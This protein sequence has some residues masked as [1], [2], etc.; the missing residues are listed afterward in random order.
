M[1]H[2]L[3]ALLAAIAA[4]VLAQSP[5]APVAP[6]APPPPSAAASAPETQRIEI[7]GGRGSET[8]QRR[9]ATAAKTIIGRDEIDQYGDSTVG[10]VLRR[11]PGV[12]TGGTPGRGGP[13]R[14]RGL[15]GGYTQLLIDGERI[16][17][18]FSLESITPDQVERIEI[19]RAPTAETGAR[20]IAGTINI[21]LREGF[22]KRLND[23]NL[24]LSQEAGQWARG[25]F[26]THNDSVDKLTYNLTA[27][28][29][30]RHREDDSLVLTDRVGGDAP[31]SAREERFA[32]DRRRGLSLG[33][34]LQWRL[35][36]PGDLLT[37]SPNL[38]AST[39]RGTRDALRVQEG[40]S[41]P[42]DS[43]LTRFD[44]SFSN[45]RLNGQWRQALGPGRLEASTT[46]SAFR[47]ENDSQR[48]EFTA[49]AASRRTDERSDTRQTSLLLSGKYTVLLGGDEAKKGSEHSLVTGGEIKTTQRRE[50]S[51]LLQDGA[52]PLS[53]F[54]G[55]LSA[56]TTRL[57]LYGQNEWNPSPQWSAHVGLRWEG[58]RTVGDLG[59]TADPDAGAR[60]RNLASV[61]TP[62]LHA[63]W[64]PDPAS[65]SQLRASLTRAW[66]SPAP[67]DLIAR[68]RINSQDGPEIENGPTTAD[69]AGN[70]D[71][72]PELS[73]GIDLAWEHY[74]AG[75]GV[76]SV[77]LFH[78]RISDLMRNVTALEDV[79]WSEQRRYV[80]RM[81]NVGDAVTQ[82]V[83][84]EAKGRVDEWIIGGPRVEARASASFFRS[85]VSSVPG[86]DN[87]LE[88]QPAAT[89]NLGA[90]YK[91]PGLPVK[92]GGNLNFVPGYRTQ[93]SA[94]ETAHISA[95]RV[96]D[97][98][99]LWTVQPGVA[100]R[101]SAS[102]L[103]PR[104][105]DD[106]TRFVSEG[107]TETRRTLTASDVN[108]QLRL[109]LKL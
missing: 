77:S 57:A 52:D 86:P 58:I 17:R 23:L 44:G 21:I 104:D 90:D 94:D 79:T 3:A 2:A 89:L 35:G 67:G 38:F 75:G 54:D 55:N 49:G 40:A 84:L 43:A 85:R 51:A 64:K 33:A 83:E 27:G 88:Q 74:P 1:K 96:F 106:Q 95:R 16:P 102:N 70:P 36:E 72:R 105:S 108:W 69:R 47:A 11:L 34:R 19:L 31:F 107:V 78:K 5:D 25:A 92:A 20:A 98:Y 4:P 39:N 65:R 109:E 101:I 99:G 53:G 9:R 30:L 82:G 24:S 10:E 29:F 15:G 14:L 93:V 32:R 73:T 71:L 26:W 60:P 103:A 100:L 12:S 56:G 45:F 13:P 81:R 63:V 97:L 46:A 28:T 59:D 87:R 61:W 80:T 18:G 6:A 42:Y 37:L 7:T 76:F 22:R 50:R 41:T 91:L 66:R 68:P 62:L 8:E 48:D